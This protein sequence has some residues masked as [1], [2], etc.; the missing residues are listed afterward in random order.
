MTKPEVPNAF[1][2]PGLFKPDMASFRKSK[3]GIYGGA[4]RAKSANG[5]AVPGL[6]TKNSRKWKKRDEEKK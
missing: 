4:A 5:D 2:T 6:D 3:S 1:N